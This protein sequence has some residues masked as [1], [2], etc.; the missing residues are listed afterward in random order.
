MHLRKKPYLKKHGEEQHIRKPP[1]DMVI[2]I[3]ICRT[4][5]NEIEIE[6]LGTGEFPA[7]SNKVVSFCKKMS[8]SVWEFLVVNNVVE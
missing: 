6:F 1:V 2:N 7:A 8:K 3:I 4:L 5:K